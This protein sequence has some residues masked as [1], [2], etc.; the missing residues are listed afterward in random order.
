M[1]NPPLMKAIRGLHFQQD[2][3]AELRSVNPDEWPA[4]LKQIDRSQ[5][6]LPLGIRCQEYLPDF[7]R[8][9]IAQNLTSNAA[10]HRLLEAEY[11]LISEAFRARS[12]DFIVLKGPSQIATLYVSNADYRPQYDID[13]Y[14]PPDA[15]AS[16]RDVLSSMGFLSLPAGAKY[17]DHLPPMIRNLDWKWRGDYY[18]P[19]LPLTVELHFRF[20]DQKTERLPAPCVEDFWRR[21]CSR[22]IRGVEV[23]MLSLADSV[24]YSAL[25]L[26]RHLLRGGIRVYHAYEIAHFLHQTAHDDALW[27]DW[28]SGR[29]EA[30]AALEVIAFR[31]ATEWFGCQTHPIVDEK[32]KRLP[33][34]IARW[35]DLFSLSPLDPDRP[36]K[37]ELFLHLSL[38]DNPQDRRTVIVRRLAPLPPAGHVELGPPDTKRSL[39][40]VMNGRVRAA[41]FFGVRAAHHA[42]TAANLIRSLYRWKFSGR[43]YAVS[44]EWPRFS[45][46]RQ[47]V[48][49]PRLRIRSGS[50]VRLVFI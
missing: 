9:R 17:S 5:L 40:G 27:G 15:V 34:R 38:L 4:L 6:T 3:R 14:C 11:R 12:I 31:L 41:Y 1:L 28:N 32:M 49:D 10:R 33:A 48:A 22:I 36:N 25:H 16:A 47:P 35:F 29:A 24:S 13:L 21:R 44:W 18:A 23:P 26:M 50:I 30:P 39:R 37:D 46:H 42:R 20:W 19:D 8:S 2:R 43:K 7:V 45:C